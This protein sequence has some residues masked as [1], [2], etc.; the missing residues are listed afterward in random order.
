MDAY[1]RETMEWLDLRY[2]GTRDGYYFAHQPIYGFRSGHS[3]LG[4]LLFYLRTWALARTLA[5]LNFDSVLDVGGSE[6]YQASVYRDL[7]GKQVEV[8][9]LSGEAAKRAAEIYGLSAR[10]ADI[11]DLPYPDEAFD[12]CTCSETIEHVPDPKKAVAELLRVAKKG[13]V[14]TVPHEPV[15]EVEHMKEEAH[16]HAHINAFDI[17]SFDYLKESGHQVRVQKIQSSQLRKYGPFV[18]GVKREAGSTKKSQALVALFNLAIP[19]ARGFFNEK[20]V[21]KM[22]ARDASLCASGGDYGGVLAVIAKDPALFEGQPTPITPEAIL[23]R[24]VP[25]HRLPESSGR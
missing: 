14:V 25:L 21:A 6:G 19:I 16:P 1:T 15:E 12:I 10:Q 23:T 8:C 2:R 24:K 17:H 22:M 9:D 3:E 11:H 20:S 18:D 13:V 4:L 5:G 7:L